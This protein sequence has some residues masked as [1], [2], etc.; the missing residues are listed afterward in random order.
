MDI[1]IWII[2][3]VVIFA[4]LAVILAWWRHAR[5]GGAVRAVRGRDEDRR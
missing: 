5:R 1:L 4:V 2:I 3:A